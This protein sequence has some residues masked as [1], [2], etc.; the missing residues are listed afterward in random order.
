MHTSSSI[1]N[2]TIIQD[3]LFARSRSLLPD[4]RVKNSYRW[5]GSHFILFG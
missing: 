5:N 2:I 4:L 1:D 3:R